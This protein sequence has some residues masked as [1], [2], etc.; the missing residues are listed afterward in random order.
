MRKISAWTA[1]ALGATAA[2]AGCRPADDAGSAPGT[3]AEGFTAIPPSERITALGTEP[4]WNIE[5][6]GDLATYA[7]PELPDGATIE[8]RRFT[9]QGGLGFSGKW[10]GRS[11]DLLVTPGTCSDG[12]SDRTYPYVATLQLGDERREGCAY[13][14]SEPFAGPQM[15]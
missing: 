4:F 15:P 2:L 3:S 11:F 10:E 5:V 14:A 8:L 13:T 9:G 12:M 7:T 6:A 1:I